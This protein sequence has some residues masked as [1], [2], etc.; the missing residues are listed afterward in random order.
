MSGF[1]TRTRL[2]DRDIATWL[3]H[4]VSDGAIASPE[5]INLEATA[6]AAEQSHGRLQIDTRPVDGR[7]HT[8]LHYDD[9]A[10]VWIPMPA[11]GLERR[12]GDPA[13]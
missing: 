3:V 7:W 2:S 13:V 6:L 8:V 9:G 4:A 12:R 10:T 5:A 1:D 11:E